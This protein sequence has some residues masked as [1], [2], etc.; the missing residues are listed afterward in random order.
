MK[1]LIGTYALLQEEAAQRISQQQARRAARQQ[2]PL[3]QPDSAPHAA[4]AAAAAVHG[5][6][7]AAEQPVG[8]AGGDGVAAAGEEAAPP[9]GLRSAADEL[10][11]TLPVFRIPG[12]ALTLPTS[13]G[14]VDFTPLFLSKQQLDLT[15]VRVHRPAVPSPPE[16]HTL[17]SALTLSS[18]VP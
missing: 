18:Q 9:P 17:Q 12:L 3:P 6:G 5:S 15:W 16:G 14:A 1:H 10:Q 8:A 2:A 11:G 13:A 4:A 7:V